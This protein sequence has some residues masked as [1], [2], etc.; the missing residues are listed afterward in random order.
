MAH[1]RMTLLAITSVRRRPMRS[2]RAPVSGA[3]NAD[4]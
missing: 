2:L 4:A 3:E 1:S